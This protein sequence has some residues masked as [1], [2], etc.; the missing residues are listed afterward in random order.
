MNETN[1]S[2]DQKKRQRSERRIIRG[3]VRTIGRR[4]RISRVAIENNE[5]T[6]T[7]NTT[8]NRRRG[9]QTSTT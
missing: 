3:I 7:S 4:R 1:K 5:K 6:N 2:K 8:G 9:R